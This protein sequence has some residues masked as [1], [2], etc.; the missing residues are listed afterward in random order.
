MKKYRGIIVL[1]NLGLLLAFFGYSVV[2]KEIL[3]NEGTL[4]LLPLAPVDPRSLMQGDYMNLRYAISEDISYS[5]M[6]KRGFCVVKIDSGNIARRVRFQEEKTPLH[7]GE[8]LIN[9]TLGTWG[10]N[11]GAESYFFQEGQAE[12]YANAKFGGLRVDDQ[13]NS[14]LIGLYD[15][16]RTKIE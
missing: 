16:N 3:A 4:L 5:E 9:Y 14:L 8:Y 2:K 15:Q 13:G 12:K 6:A 10:I 1:V 7:A 11:I